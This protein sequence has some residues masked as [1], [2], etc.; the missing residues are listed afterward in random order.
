LRRETETN[1]ASLFEPIQ[2]GPKRLKNR[3]VLP[4]MSTNFGH[5]DRPGCVSERHMAYYGERALGGTGLI[6]LESTASL[7]STSSR[8]LGL[9][10]YEDRFIPGLAEIVQLIK[11]SGA[12]CGIQIA[13]HGVGRLGALKADAEGQPDTSGMNWGEY[14][15][16]SP[17]PHPIT[18]VIARQL[19]VNQLKEIA[20]QLG[21]AALRARKA[22]FD[23]IEIHGAHGYLLHEFLSPRTN[24]RTD[25]YGGDIGGRSLFPLEVVRRIRAV[26]GDEVALSYRLSATEFIEGGLDVDDCIIFAKKLQTE[27]VNVIHIS[28]GTNETAATMN[29]VIPPMSYPKG[30]LIPYAQRIKS[31]V[32][33]P[34]IAVQRINTPELANEIVREGKADLVATGRA[35][36]ADPHWPL[37]AQQGRAEEIRK[38]IACN[39]GCMEQIVL[40]NSLTCLHNPEV[41]YEHLYGLKKRV[42]VGKRVLVVGGGPAGMEAATVLAE[43]GC[44]VRLVE[45]EERLGGMARL[46]SLNNEKIE[47]SG[48]TE[49]FRG[50]LE[51]LG[52]EV[53]L[54]EQ[55]DPSTLEQGEQEFSFDE[56]VVAIGSKA[57]AP[58]VDGHTSRYRV[59][60]ATEALKHP[61]N[62]GQNVF[63]IGGGSV[64]IEVAGYLHL[65]A[66]KVTVIEMTA[67]ICADLGP[68]NRADVLE[69]LERQPITVMLRTKVIELSD[70]GVRVL[71]DGKEDC[72]R[73]P[74]TV[75][76][77]MG[78]K[79]ASI[80]LPGVDVPIHY[81]GDCKKVGNAMDAIH[82]AFKVAVSLS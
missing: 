22:G 6:I 77:A 57:L 73:D 29:R 35:L 31:A 58:V 76:V 33:V 2:V 25:Q 81:V 43:R 19:S 67:G 59:Y 12:A 11:A 66:K 16:A 27:G 38:C 9:G 15:A 68:L 65:L 20:Q 3:I 79:P 75:I 39:Q 1:F 45:K 10:L 53:K 51:R 40:G 60:M 28:G 49:Y 56:I 50:R 14:F 32:S 23:L 7:A 37:K 70:E 54:G 42:N 71:K 4:A 64:G 69:R 24:K 8:K 74:D 18:G 82:H 80:S 41:G 62:I 61:E 17:L 52:V 47:F 36:I 5:P 21:E 78:A 48:V 63:I 34:V 72:F 13:P 30:R 46:G 44:I 55:I 26:V